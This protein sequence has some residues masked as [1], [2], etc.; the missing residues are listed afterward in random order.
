M[1]TTRIQPTTRLL[2]ATLALAAVA[3]VSPLLPRRG[4]AGLRNCVDVTGPQSGRVG[5]YEDVWADGVE[6]RMTFSNTRSRA[7]PRR[8]L[9]LLRP[10]AA[11]GHAAGLAAQPFL[12]DHVV[13]TV[14]RQNHGAYSVQLQGF[15]VFCSGQGIAS[16]ACVPVLDPEPAEARSVREDRQRAA[17]HV[18][19]GDRV[20]R[21]RRRSRARQPRPR[22]RA[23]RDYQRS[24]RPVLVPG[25]RPVARP[26]HL[27]KRERKPTWP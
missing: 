14:P 19:R 6:Y 16:G 20:G 15:F 5:C 21:G 23:H 9:T 10:C 2:I 25:G 17:A 1:I 11:D 7:R 12:H 27:I 4:A 26:D 3:S 18:H 13:R 24:N 8:N 22:R